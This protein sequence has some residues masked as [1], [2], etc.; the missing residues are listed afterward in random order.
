MAPAGPAPCWIARDAGR[1]GALLDREHATRHGCADAR[2]AGPPAR[3][4]ARE[5][6]SQRG[7]G[8]G[9]AYLRM[10]TARAT[11]STTVTIE[12]EAC[13]VMAILAQRDS[14]M[15]SVGLNAVALVNDRYR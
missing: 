15:T 3:R 1:A 6:C 14:G 11:T 4:V 5:G 12:T 10:L 7:A 9:S 2:R 8:P 13:T